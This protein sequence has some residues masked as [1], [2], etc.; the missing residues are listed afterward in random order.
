MDAASKMARALAHEI[1]NHLGSMRTMLHLLAEEV[2]PDP[3]VKEDLQFVVRS[4]EAATQLVGSLRAF[5]RAPALGAGPADLNAVLVQAE[6]ALRALLRPGTTLDI[7]LATEPLPVTADEQRLAQLVLDLVVGADHVLPVGG[8]IRVSTERAPGPAGAAPAAALVVRD[9]G[10]GLEPEAAV[11]IFEPFVFDVAHDSGLRL[12]AVF[13]T[14]TRSGGTIA[15]RSAPG[16]GTAFRVTLPL[17][18]AAPEAAAP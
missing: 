3:R 17:V 5:V 4:V 1:A 15:A 2:G 7:D 12:P 10:P 8:R 16:A 9:D 18:T 6:P 13:N 11:R 14:V